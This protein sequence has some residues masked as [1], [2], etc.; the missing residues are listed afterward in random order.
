MKINWEALVFFFLFLR[1]GVEFVGDEGKHNQ[2]DNAM[3]PQETHC[4]KSVKVFV[5]NGHVYT[6]C[7]RLYQDSVLMFRASEKITMVILT[8]G[9][10]EASL[11]LL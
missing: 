2:R 7:Q 5:K 1:L 11:S 8:T 3:T 9:R 6:I 4:D 10:L